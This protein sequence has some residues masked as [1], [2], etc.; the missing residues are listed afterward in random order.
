LQPDGR[1]ILA[2]QGQ[3]W[4]TIPGEGMRYR[5]T[6]QTLPLEFRKPVYF[7]PLGSTEAPDEARIE[8]QLMLEPYTGRRSSENA[9]AESEGAS[10]GTSVDNTTNDTDTTDANGENLTLP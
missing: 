10:A 8:I 5:A 3:I 1:Y 2:A 9:G 7:F 4:I 6:M